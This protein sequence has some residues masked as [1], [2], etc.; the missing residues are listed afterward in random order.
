[1]LSLWPELR[2]GRL[3][4]LRGVVAADP[5]HSTKVREKM[6]REL[7]SREHIDPFGRKVRISRQ[8][9][10]RWIRD[11]RA[12]EFDALVPNPPQSMP[13]TPVEVLQLAVA[14]RR[15][16]PDRT[17]EVIQRILRTRLGWALDER[18]LQR[19]FHRV[20]FT[21][22]TVGRRGRCSAGS[23]RPHPMTCGPGMCCT[24]SGLPSARPIF[25]FLD[26]H[27]GY[28]RDTAG[29]TRNTP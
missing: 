19:H 3:V 26:G 14:L 24:A 18:I 1:L 17:A 7:A 2:E 23:K 15:E 27:S 12:G 20:G 5:A 21:T 9:L 10:D 11:W 22:A 28:C 16:N 8:T 29:A 6:V 25:A 4:A 13:R